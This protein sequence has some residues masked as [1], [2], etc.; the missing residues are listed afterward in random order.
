M[1]EFL[2]SLTLTNSRSAIFFT[3]TNEHF[4]N[5]SCYE[6]FKK[7]HRKTA[8]QVAGQKI[9]VIKCVADFLTVNISG[10]NKRDITIIHPLFWKKN[11]CNLEVLLEAAITK[12]EKYLE[13][14]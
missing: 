5:N 6:I 7:T 11:E 10:N 13:N 3:H 9:P 1:L 12:F 14:S 2:F 4:D 8:F